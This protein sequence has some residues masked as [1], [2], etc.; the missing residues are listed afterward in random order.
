M[1]I[2]T[3]LANLVQLLNE[4]L[5]GT[6]RTNAKAAIHDRLSKL[7]TRLKCPD[8]YAGQAG[9]NLYE[10]VS[11]RIRTQLHRKRLDVHC[12]SLLA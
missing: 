11:I 1:A 10:D 8:N 12:Y 5:D 2:T 6:A 7:I 4:N 3:L 9:W